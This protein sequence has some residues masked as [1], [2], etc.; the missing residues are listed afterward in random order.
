MSKKHVLVV[1]DD[2]KSLYALTVVLEQEGCKVAGF[3]SPTE[4]DVDVNELS[5]AVIDLRLPDLPGAQFASQL[6]KKN[7][8]IRIVFVTAYGKSESDDL[9]GFPLLVK[10]LNVDELLTLI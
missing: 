2:T 4:V 1:E 3:S 9:Q 6:R 10:P 5:A 7:P 8:A